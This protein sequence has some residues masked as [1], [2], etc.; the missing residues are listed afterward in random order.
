MMWKLRAVLPVLLATW[1]VAECA[2]AQPPG[3]GRRSRRA[4]HPKVGEVVKDFELKDLKGKKVR[5]SD[6]RDKIFVLEL[7]ACT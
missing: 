4:P 5:L 1:M 2:Q 6:F 7:G 3:P